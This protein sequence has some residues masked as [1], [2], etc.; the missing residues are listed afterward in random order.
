MENLIAFF[1]F[2]SHGFIQRRR[3]LLFLADAIGITIVLVIMVLIGRLLETDGVVKSCRVGCSS[4]AWHAVVMLGAVGATKLPA[5]VGASARSE[6]TLR[7]AAA[8]AYAA[9][10]CCL[11]AS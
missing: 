7:A 8:S 11:E 1:L 10:S 9:F 4:T 5:T 2:N 6:G 3:S